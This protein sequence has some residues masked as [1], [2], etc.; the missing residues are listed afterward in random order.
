MSVC[1]WTNR[2]LVY[3]V[4]FAFMF[5]EAKCKCVQYLYLTKTET[6]YTRQSEPLLRE[7]ALRQKKRD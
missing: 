2:G 3:G 7:T 1:P 6:V 4:Y 5:T